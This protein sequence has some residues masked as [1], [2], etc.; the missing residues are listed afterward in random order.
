[1]SIKLNLGNT[2]NPFLKIPWSISLV[3]LILY[4]H[5]SEKRAS[6][7]VAEHAKRANLT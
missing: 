5:F 1:V 2:N 7:L 3:L 6:L 4:L